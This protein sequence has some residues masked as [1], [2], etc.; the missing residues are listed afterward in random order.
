MFYPAMAAIPEWAPPGE[1]HI[2]YSEGVL[3]NVVYSNKEINYTATAK[4]G[5]ST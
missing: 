1:N 2:L 3:K 5:W 4:E